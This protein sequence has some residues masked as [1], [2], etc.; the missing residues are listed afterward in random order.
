M[1]LL[2]KQDFCNM[3]TIFPKCLS[4]ILVVF[5]AYIYLL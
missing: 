3:G 5:G 4:R 1:A 2:F